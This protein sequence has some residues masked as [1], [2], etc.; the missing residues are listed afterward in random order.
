LS[1]TPL[2]FQCL[3]KVTE[4]LDAPIGQN[5]KALIEVL[6]QDDAAGQEVFVLDRDFEALQID[7]L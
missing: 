3:P 5:S 7:V 6:P 4:S 1:H 2:G